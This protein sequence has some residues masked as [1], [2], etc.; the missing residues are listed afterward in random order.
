MA[1]NNMSR[2]AR[3]RI[4][5]IQ[6]AHDLFLEHG[7][8]GTSMRQIATD[9]SVALSGIYNHFDSKED[10]FSTV[11]DFYHPYHEILP[12]LNHAQ[13]ETI[14]DFV[15]DAAD[16]MISVLERRPDFLNLM[17]I[18]IVE[19]DQKHLPELFEQFFPEIM[20]LLEKFTQR[21]GNLRSIP[22]PIIIR[23]FIGMI[24]TFVLSEN[25]LQIYMPCEKEQEVRKYMV[26]IFLHGIIG[27]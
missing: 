18:E 14:E 27:G 13:G 25:V 20:I 19:F 17:F 6:S 16:S 26:D 1:Q 5:I 7:Y 8:H 23:V 22:T 15:R 10:L 9:A 4:E 2:G 21:D 24:F 11:L 3:T 12:I